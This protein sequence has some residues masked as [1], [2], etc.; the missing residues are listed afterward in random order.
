VDELA[1]QAQEPASLTQE[2]ESEGQATA[3]KALA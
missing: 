3:R 2:L 1:R